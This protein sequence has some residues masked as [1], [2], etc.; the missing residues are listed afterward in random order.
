MDD[1]EACKRIKDRYFATD[2]IL[3]HYNCRIYQSVKVYGQAPCD[4]GLIHDLD[5]LTF[6]ELLYPNFIVDYKKS[7]QTDEELSSEEID[8][9]LK[10]LISHFPDYQPILL[11]ETVDSPDFKEMYSIAV[12]LFGEKF[13]NENYVLFKKNFPETLKDIP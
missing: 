9:M 3:H 11:S 10:E 12:E 2:K 5:E 4:C 13:A 7:Y 1:M 6:P 8:A